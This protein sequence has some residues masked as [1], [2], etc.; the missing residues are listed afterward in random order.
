MTPTIKDTIDKQINDLY[1]KIDT[2]YQLDF[3]DELGDIPIDMRNKVMEIESKL[4]VLFDKIKQL[5][6]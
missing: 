1:E 4:S 6:K 5:N 2:I 3:D